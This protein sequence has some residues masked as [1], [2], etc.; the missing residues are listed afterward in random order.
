[1]SGKNTVTNC[2]F[3]KNNYPTQKEELDPKA[4]LNF[5]RFVD[6]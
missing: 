4:K 6:F 1:M 2:K 3:V 5:K